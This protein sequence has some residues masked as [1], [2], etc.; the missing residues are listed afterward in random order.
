V[1]RVEIVNWPKAEGPA[2]KSGT[3]KR[4]RKERVRPNGREDAL[5]DLQ[6]EL[7]LKIQQ[8]ILDRLR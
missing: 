8:D 7:S 4:V 3:R 1:T 5:R 2:E 6:Y